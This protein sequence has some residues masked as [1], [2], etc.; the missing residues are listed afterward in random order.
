MGF[1]EFLS[2]PSK[3]MIGLD[4]S[5][6]AVKL[7]ELSHNGDNYKVE[8]YRVLPLPPNTVVEK[9]VADIEAL[10]DTISNVLKKS[11]TKVR[12]AAVAV[13][14]SSVITKEIELPAGLNDMQMEMQIEVEAD[15]Y[16]PYPME[17]VAY[18]FEVLGPVEGN[19]GLVRVLLAACRQENVEHRRE[20]LE[21]AGLTP[22]VVDVEG[23]AIERAYRLLEDQLEQMGEQV[24]AIADVGATM[25]TF[26]VLVG[27]KTIYTREQL[28]GGKQLTE[29]IQ[30]RYGLSNEE[31]GEAKRKGGLPED[32][33]SEV[34]TPFKEALVQ[35]ITRSLQ[36]FYSS[37]H[38]N[39]VDQLFLAGGV[40]AIPGLMDEV[41]QSV[42]LPTA[43]A[44]PLANMQISKS[45]NASA[46]AN[47]APAMMLAV[48]LA[49]RGFE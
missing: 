33:E 46:L 1:F 31:A 28:F 27:G 20:A 9:N 3:P 49:L 36:F 21:K 39:Y 2:K 37:S 24:V 22:K 15:Q 48:G 13:A 5:S 4:I 30:R 11:G 42:G 14:G 35:Q 18:D 47:D 26:S 8:A 29:E 17:E 23:F 40:S 32:Y 10:A 6:S 44:N 38:Y 19:D 41:E 34:L 43:V 12:D 25:F 16:I 7:I 45:V